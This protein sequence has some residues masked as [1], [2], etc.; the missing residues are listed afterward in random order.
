[1][2]FASCRK[3]TEGVITDRPESIILNKNVSICL[4]IQHSLR[5]P[6]N[7]ITIQVIPDRN[8]YKLQIDSQAMSN[9]PEWEYTQYQRKK[10]ISQKQHDQLLI[11]LEKV[12]WSKLKYEPG[13]DGE[14]WSLK[15]NDEGRAKLVT[16]FCPYD[17]AE[18]YKNFL[19][20]AKLLLS[21][22][23]IDYDKLINFDIY[24]PTINHLPPETK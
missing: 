7:H 9:N 2:F 12:E 5:I 24:E 21:Y 11:A 17:E 10:I 1:M 3:K 18:K 4:I 6:D 19:T 23:G 22:T 15:Y 16:L 20:V 14:T 13:L 8:E